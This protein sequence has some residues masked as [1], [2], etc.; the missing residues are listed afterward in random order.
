MHVP[1]A[2]GHEDH[3]PIAELIVDVVR[4]ERER[5]ER[6][7][8]LPDRASPELGLGTRSAVRF[9]G[10]K[11]TAV[12]HNLL[13][14]GLT[15]MWTIFLFQVSLFLVRARV[16]MRRRISGVGEVGVWGEG[17]MKW[18]GQPSDPFRLPTR[19]ARRT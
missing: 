15:E 5:V 4:R 17:E 8:R 16:L 19:L 7:G 14:P 3:V 12:E 2:I 18:G 10:A 9:V 1:G 6:E 11:S 13:T